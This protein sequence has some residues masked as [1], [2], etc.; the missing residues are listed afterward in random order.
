MRDYLIVHAIG[1][2]I[3]LLSASVISINNHR[4]LIFVFFTFI[5]T[6]AV[7]FNVLFHAG[8]TVIF[9]AYC[10]GLITAL[11]IYT[12]LFFAISYLVLRE[13]LLTHRM[14]VVSFVVAGVVHAT[15]VAHNVF[16]AL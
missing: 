12:P 1:L 13:Q 11:Y 9:R 14:A 2:L 4:I 8:T 5:F 7:F 3:A 16:K 15:D 10:P 6:P